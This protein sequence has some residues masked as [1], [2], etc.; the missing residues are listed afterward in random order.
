MKAK[1]LILACVLVGGLGTTV[2]MLVNAQATTSRSGGQAAKLIKA[3][4]AFDTIERVMTKEYWLNMQKEVVALNKQLTAATNEQNALKKAE[5]EKE[6]YTKYFALTNELIA[7]LSGVMPFMKAANL[8]LP[9]G[10]LL[11]KVGVPNPLF[12]EPGQKVAMG[13][14]YA[15]LIL[16]NLATL[17]AVIQQKVETNVQE[18]IDDIAAELAALAA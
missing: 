8:S 18:D 17:N 11:A 4:E 7:T 9:G 13:A 10:S 5:M 15:E 14:K 16:K 6:I 2:N 3:L 1:K 12:G